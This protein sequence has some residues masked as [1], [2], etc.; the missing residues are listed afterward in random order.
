MI[1]NHH[2]VVDAE[3]INIY[4]VV[5]AIEAIFGEDALTFEQDDEVLKYIHIYLDTHYDDTIQSVDQHLLNLDCVLVTVL[6]LEDKLDFFNHYNY[7][8]YN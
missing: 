3:Q 4:R 8:I 7:T 1:I 5:R 6:G 2:Y